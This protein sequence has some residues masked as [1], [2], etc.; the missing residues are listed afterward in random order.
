MEKNINNIINF[1]IMTSLNLI[2]LFDLEEIIF[3]FGLS[4]PIFSFIYLIFLIP[5][6]KFIFYSLI[7]SIILTILYLYR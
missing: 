1:Y 2:D 4:S 3:K 6:N 5:S 7:I